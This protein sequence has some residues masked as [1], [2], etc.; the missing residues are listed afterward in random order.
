[1]ANNKFVIVNKE[2]SAKKL[3]KALE[4]NKASAI[5][6]AKATTAIIIGRATVKIIPK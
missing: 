5:A 6:R 3:R 2:L 4:L 1:M